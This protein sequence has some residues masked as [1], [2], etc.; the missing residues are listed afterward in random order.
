[1]G[2][3]SGGNVVISSDVDEKKVSEGVDENPGVDR[4]AVVVWLFVDG[5]TVKKF[6]SEGVGI[7]G[8]RW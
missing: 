2:D 1:V 4:A 6:E 7:A 3:V 8:C 5:E